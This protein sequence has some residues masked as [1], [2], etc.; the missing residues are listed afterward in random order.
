[1]GK[2]TAMVVACV[3]VLAACGDD[4]YGGGGDDGGGSTDDGASSVTFDDLVGRTF[5]STSVTG[6]ELVADSQVEL[7][8]TE[9]RVSAIAGCNTQTGGAD[10]ADGTLVVDGLASTQMACEDDLQE[11][12]TWLAGFLDDDPDSALEGDQLTLTSGDEVLELAESGA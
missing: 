8:F 5:T 6:H 10:V 2:L 1:M 9:G 7:T 3:L 11:Q 4:G 12:D